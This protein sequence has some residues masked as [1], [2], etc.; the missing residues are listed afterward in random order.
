[1]HYFDKALDT[2]SLRDL[3]ALQNERLRTLVE[4]CYR[5][6]PYYKNL[7]DSVRLKPS[8]VRTTADLAHVPFTEKKDLRGLYPYGL[9]GFPVDQIHRF[10]ASSGTTGVPTLVGYTEKDW[11]VTMAEQ[12]GR[13]WASYDI[14]PEDLVYQSYGYGLFLG[15]ACAEAGARAVGATLFPAGPGRTKAAIEWLRDMKH[16]VICCTPS[17]IRYLVGEAVDAGVD[18]KRDWILRRGCF[19]GEMAAPAVRRKVEAELPDGFVYHDIY[20]T[21]EM[22]GST[23]AGSC[24]ASVHSC[25]MHVLG[26][27]YFVEV[28]DPASGERV[29]PGEMGELVITTLTKEA[30]PFIRWRTRD[31]SRLAAE[32]YGCA[33]GRAAH[34]LID[35]ITG[36]SD[37]VLK[38]RGTL[39]FPSQIEDILSRIPGVGEGWQ[40]VIDAE[41]SALDTLN[42]MAE[43]DASCWKDKERLEKVRGEIFAQVASRQGITPVVELCEPLSLPRFEGKAK[44]VVDRRAAH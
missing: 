30:T 20:G 28:I 25:Q 38:V 29:E 11:Q 14:G 10:A 13:L 37:D 4:R 39:V 15:G 26:D 42:I 36:R 9:L 3:E 6:I 16:S 18:P 19:G 21:S 17:F 31:I 33:C 1:M 44:R 43:A 22:G 23:V 2:I 35:R 7:F 34:P 24:P 8:H 40:I 5:T 27:H 32:P 12:M 41:R